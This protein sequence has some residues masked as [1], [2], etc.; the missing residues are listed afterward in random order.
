[1]KILVISRNAWDDTNAIGNTL[2]NFFAGI[3]NVEFA[4]IY[5]RSAKPNNALCRRYY[6]TSEMEVLKNWFAP[7]NIGK[8]FLVD[9]TEKSVDHVAGEK[10]E[11]KLIRFIHKHGVNVAYKLS[12]HIWYSKKWINGNLRDFIESFSPDLIFTFVKSAPQY[13]LTIRYLRENFDIPLLSW[14]AD[15]EYTGLAQKKAHTE[16]E[17]LKY[18]L[19]ESAVVWGCSKEICDYYNSLFACEATPLYKGC[20]LTTPVKEAVNDPIKMVYAGNLLYG[21]LDIVQQIAD[22]LETYGSKISFEIYSNTTLTAAERSWFDQKSRTKYMGRK[23]YEII[24]QQLSMADIVL[25]AESFD[26][27]QI[28]KTK[29]SFSTKIIDCL[30][31]GSVLLAIG[32]KEIASIRYIQRIPGAYVI[33]DIAKMREELIAVLNDSANF[34]RRANQMREF[35]KK[36]HEKAGNSRELEAVMKKIVGRDL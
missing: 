29:Y 6:H 5:F 16:I 31:S 11:K 32:P 21:R 24:K 25:H 17:N 9:E 14:I 19:K 30:Q 12:D 10:K 15:D 2:S 36:Y 34:C 13:Y 8:Q 23:D 3:D 27:A 7:G 26:D 1:M 4:S 22:V 20:D 35:A 18:I 33:S 28:L